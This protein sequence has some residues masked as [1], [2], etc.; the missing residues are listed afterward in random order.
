MKSGDLAAYIPEA[1]V[2]PDWLIKDMGLEGKLAGSK[3]NRVKA[4]RLRS[5]LSQGLVCPVVDGRL[6]GEEVMEG[7]DVTG[8]L[9]L[10]K[11]EPPIPIHMAGQVTNMHGCTIKYDIEDIKKYPNVLEE[12]ELVLV[13]EKLHGTWCCLGWHPDHGPVVSSKGVSARGLAFKINEENK[14]NLY[15]KAW[16]EHKDKIEEMRMLLTNGNE[17]FYVLGEVYG[18]G[19]QDLHYGEMHPKFAMFDVY[20]GQP[21]QGGY[22]TYFIE[23]AWRKDLFATV[24]VLASHA[25]YSHEMLLDLT[26]GD[27]A[28][29]ATCA[30]AWWCAP[31]RK[32]RIR[33]G[34]GGAQERVRPIPDAQGRRDGVQ[35]IFSMAG[36]WGAC[37]AI[38]GASLWLKRHGTSCLHLRGFP[39]VGSEAGAPSPA[40]Q[41]AAAVPQRGVAKIGRR[42]RRHGRGQRRETDVGI[43]DGQDGRVARSPGA[44]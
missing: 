37:D 18:R 15:V 38:A 40:V 31:C 43:Q 28:L 2:C 42:G 25:P 21:G 34:Q 20:I 4:I 9:G 41:K 29:A 8:L 1:S 35:L 27:S 13:T 22:D 5:V 33:L 32:G 23:T 24:P 10:V 19:V 39:R 16:H 7:Q 14:D 26:D 36:R 3:K 44:P 11:Y 17:P 6:Y 12:G 30:K